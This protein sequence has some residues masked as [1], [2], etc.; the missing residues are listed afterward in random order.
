MA[1]ETLGNLIAAAKGR[2]DMENSSFISESLWITFINKG[3]GDLYDLLVSNYGDDFFCKTGTPVDVASGA[4]E[5][6]L[7][8]DFHKLVGIDQYYMGMWKPMK[9]FQFAERY[10]LEGS[11][12]APR[13]CIQADKV[14]I[15]PSSHSSLKIQMIYVPEFAKLSNLSDTFNFKSSW[16]DFVILSAAIKAKD[17]EESDVSVLMIEL[18]RAEANIIKASPG[19]DANRPK[20][21]IDI[22]SVDSAS[23]WG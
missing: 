18:Q 14:L 23:L 5:V 22:E 21:I 3:L 1:T 2:A 19:R 7:P 12:C 15:R 9:D 6:A 4:G 8:S 16:A 13:Y 10:L 17:K 20:R 11:S